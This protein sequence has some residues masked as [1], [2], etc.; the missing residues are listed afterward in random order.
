[1]PLWSVGNWDTQVQVNNIW[2][3]DGLTDSDFCAP[4]Y[5]HKYYNMTVKLTRCRPNMFKI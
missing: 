2:H 5:I 4:Q 3:V 1:M